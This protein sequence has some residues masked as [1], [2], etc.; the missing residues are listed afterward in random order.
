MIIVYRKD[1]KGQIN[2]MCEERGEILVL[3]LAVPILAT[4]RFKGLMHSIYR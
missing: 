1:Y 4:V 2:R 3:K